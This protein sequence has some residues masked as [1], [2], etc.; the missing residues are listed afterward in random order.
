M[1]NPLVRLPKPV[2]RG[3]SAMHRVA[4][5]ATGG[6][7]ATKFRGAPSVLL[8]TTGR[9]TGKKRTWPLLG[10]PVGDGYALAASNGGHDRHPAWYL[11][12][13]A[14]P[15]V[16]LQVGRTTIHGKARTATPAERAEL[17]PKFVDVFSGYRDYEQATER[18]IPVVIVEPAP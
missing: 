10:I 5:K 14:D 15:A 6:R 4:V 13:Q 9:K 1:R 17:Y 8:T 2:I 7:V 18:H 12:L 3:F 16:E 11:N